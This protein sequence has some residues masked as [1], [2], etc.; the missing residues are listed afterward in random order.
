MNMPD[1][2]LLMELLQQQIRTDAELAQ[3]LN[4]QNLGDH[5]PP[6]ID[7]TKLKGYKKRIGVEA[8]ESL[9][10]LVTVKKMNNN[11]ANVSIEGDKHHFDNY[12]N[13][14]G[15]TQIL[16]TKDSKLLLLLI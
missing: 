2:G 6:D 1:P 11:G 16:A 10:N 8:K 12:N 7:V 13:N 15:K 9:L 5:S 3:S 14:G 4:L